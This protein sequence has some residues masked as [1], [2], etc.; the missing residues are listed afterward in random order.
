MRV[1]EENTRPGTRS[2]WPVEHAPPGAIEGYTTQTSTRPG[3]RIELC[4]S[5]APA[6]R[7]EIVVYRLGWYGG[8]G[9]REILRTPSRMGLARP[10]PEP[11]AQTGLVAAAWPVTDSLEIPPDAASGHWVAHLRLST[12]PH[13]G[14]TALVPFVVRP[15]LD[16]PPDVLVQ[17]PVNTL[18]AYNHWGGRCLYESNSTDNRPAVKVSFDRPVPAWAESNLNSKAPLHYDL[19]LA[20][21]MERHGYDVGYQSDVDTHREPWTLVPPRMLVVSG[22]D[23]YWSR[24]IRQAF[25]EAR[26]RGTS[27]AFMGANLV[28]WQVRYEDDERTLVGYKSFADDPEPDG[29]L[30]TAQFRQ[31]DPAWEERELLGTQYE[32]GLT[33][34]NRLFDYELDPAS[35]DD[36]W[37]QGTGFAED[38]SPVQ[39]VVGYEWDGIWR[40]EPPPGMV[41]FLHFDHELGPA[42]CLRW[43]APSGARIFS[44]GSLGLVHALD[45]WA[46]GGDGDARVERL[47]RN[48]FDDLASS[49]PEAR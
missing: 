34:P 25:D 39:A 4:V 36:P 15:R 38:R 6:A 18:Q 33:K 3:Q 49:P 23:E 8:D 16:E 47:V 30:K 13:A 27:L 29:A 1:A 11:D 26:D 20:R 14:T 10:V 12:G 24:E 37:M 42:D 17:T 21:W 5:T 22:H 28:F 46:R 40:D 7:Y 48:A 45:G 31:L 44:I 41:R 19:P 32:K 9:A 35:L 2:W 43:T